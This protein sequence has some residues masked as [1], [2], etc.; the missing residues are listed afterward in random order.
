[1]AIKSECLVKSVV[2]EQD[3]LYLASWLWGCQ[4]GWL[5]QRT[6]HLGRSSPATRRWLR[7]RPT[8]AGTPIFVLLFHRRECPN[9]INARK[10]TC[11]NPSDICRSRRTDSFRGFLFTAFSHHHKSG[12]SQRN[13]GLSSVNDLQAPSI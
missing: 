6:N 7:S 9:L 12:K 3:S 10:A 2:S 13:K 1:M 11:V 8:S 5:R 4:S